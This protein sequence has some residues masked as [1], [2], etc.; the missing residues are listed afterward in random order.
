MNNN[1]CKGSHFSSNE[2]DLD[3]KNSIYLIPPYYYPNKYLFIWRF[4]PFAI[5]L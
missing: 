3:L 4:P 5:S 2:K 1:G